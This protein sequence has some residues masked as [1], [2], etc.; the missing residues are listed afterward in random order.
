MLLTAPRAGVWLAGRMTD[1]AEYVRAEHPEQ[2]E[3]TLWVRELVLAA[4]PDLE[5]RVYPGWRG[6]GYR[7]PEAGYVCG[8]FPRSDEVHLL[9][10]HG[11]ALPDPDGVLTGGGRQTRVIRLRARDDSMT[12]TIEIYVQQAVAQRLLG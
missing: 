8:I 4:D 10:E 1:A 5:E 12:R 7:H 11:A 9:F 2:A 6:L 3:L